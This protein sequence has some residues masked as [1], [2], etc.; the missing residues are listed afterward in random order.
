[1]NAS[2]IPI[3]TR[4][5]ISTSGNLN[6]EYTYASQLLDHLG[7][8]LVMVSAPVRERKSVYVPG[9]AMVKV[10]FLNEIHGM[11]LFS[12]KVLRHEKQKTLPVLVIRP[13]GEVG[14]IQR[15]KYFRVNC[16]LDVKYTKQKDENSECDALPQTAISKNISGCGISIVVT[17]PLEPGSLVDLELRLPGKPQRS[18]LCKVARCERIQGFEEIKYEAGLEFTLISREERNE[19]IQYAFRQQRRLLRKF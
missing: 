3:G 14:T 2:E 8:G 11:M 6:D 16:S 7:D 18:L 15:R 1:M 10:M 9:G 4:L 12:A 13:V 19:I 17:E 5:G